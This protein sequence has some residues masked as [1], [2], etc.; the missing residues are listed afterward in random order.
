VKE[1]PGK[2]LSVL[3]VVALFVALVWISGFTPDGILYGHWPKIDDHPT[4]WYD[5]ALHPN[6]Q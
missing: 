5:S 6:A 4:N 2:C 3:F 1:I